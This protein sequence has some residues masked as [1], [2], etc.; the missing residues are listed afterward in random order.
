MKLPKLLVLVRSWSLYV[1]QPRRHQTVKIVA[2]LLRG[3]THRIPNLLP[4]TAAGIRHLRSD[5]ALHSDWNAKNK[6]TE[7]DCVQ[8]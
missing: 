8:V 1:E 2:L 6:K 4:T 7:F 3:E 5:F